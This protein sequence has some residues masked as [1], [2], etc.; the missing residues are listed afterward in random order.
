MPKDDKNTHH[1]IVIA[2]YGNQC[3]IETTDK[4]LLTAKSLKSIG[5]PLCG[6]KVTYRIEQNN[7][8]ILTE[9]LPRTGILSRR[10]N[11]N[12]KPKQIAANID[13]MIIVISVNDSIKFG[14]ID[15]YLIAAEFS[16]FNP[17]IVLNK[18]DLP[19]AEPERVSQEIEDIIGIDATNALQVSAKSGIGIDELLEM[20]V[21]KIPA[22][23]G[24]VDAPLQAL[25]IDS[26]CYI[27]RSNYAGHFK[28]QAEN[29]HDGSRPQLFG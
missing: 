9:I 5:K 25:I 18:I 4:E 17:I 27:A 20:L 10:N 13:Q 29:N 26:W 22:P 24:D 28:T 3:K 14:L 19:A 11:L 15:R 16:N 6:D 23:Q 8:I 1:A 2:S 12:P 21:E 7:E